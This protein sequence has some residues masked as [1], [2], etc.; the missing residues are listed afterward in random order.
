VSNKK[1]NGIYIEREIVKSKAYLSLRGFAPQL[2]MLMLEKRVMQKQGRRGKEKWS[3]TN[4]HSI[5]MTYVE[6]EKHGI[7][8]PRATRAFDDLLAKGFIS[9]RNP[10]GGYDK[11]KAIYSLS[12]NWRIWHEGCVFERR[13][14]QY[15]GF[16]HPD[17]KNKTQHT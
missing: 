8:Q 15:R 9:I 13:K 3:C 11:D 7:T 17:F 16:C 10:G 4:Y 5:N 2:L 6:L 1:S 14:K 12:E